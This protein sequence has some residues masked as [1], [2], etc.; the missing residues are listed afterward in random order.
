MRK[1]NWSSCFHTLHIFC[2]KRR[3]GKF[4]GESRVQGKSYQKVNM[5]HVQG[6]CFADTVEP[7]LRRQPRDQRG[8]TKESQ[9]IALIVAVLVA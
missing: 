5:M 2:I 7:L 4:H 9:L 6:C 8:V 3:V 1:I